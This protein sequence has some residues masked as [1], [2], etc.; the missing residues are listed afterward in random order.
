MLER[1]PGPLR[2][3]IGR[4]GLR[5][6]QLTAIAP[7]GT[8]SLLAGNVSSGIEPVFETRQR[9]RVGG[10]DGRYQEFDIPDRAV[11]AWW[12][13]RGRETLPPALVTA[14]ELGP[15]AHLAMQAA[16][17]PWVDGAISK[18]VNLPAEARPEAV[19]R[20]YAL[21]WSL[22]L[23]GCTTFRPNPVTGEVLSPVPE[24]PA[25]GAPDS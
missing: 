12:A 11:A 2:A 15:E 14:R 20:V 17:Q 1:L 25:V 9:R 8:I 6:A 23:K 21:A 4:H 7:A 13:E 24:A 3:D 10:L 18:T 16:L 19:E 5:N 22:G